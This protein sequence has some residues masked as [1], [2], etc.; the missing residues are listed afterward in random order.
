MAFVKVC[1]TNQLGANGMASFYVEG[2]EV[3]ILRDKS[4]EL[5]A[6]DGLCPHED[7]PLVTGLL[8]GGMLICSGHGWTFDATSG[9][10]I[11]PVG[12]KLSSYPVRVDGEDVLV[13]LDNPLA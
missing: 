12:C 3:L 1:L 4:G 11:N 13:D 7:H 5:R 2:L 9:A 8:E 6:L 10:G